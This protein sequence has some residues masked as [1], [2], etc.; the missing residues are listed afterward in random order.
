MAGKFYTIKDRQSGEVL[1]QGGQS[2]CMNFLGCSSSCLRSLAM[3]DVQSRKYQKYEIT[4][5]ISDLV[6]PGGRHE[7]DVICCDCGVLMKNVDATRKR[8]AECARKHALEHKR[9]KMR[10]KRSSTPLVTKK[11]T[12]KTNYCEG[13]IHYRGVYVTDLCC[14]YYFDTDKRRPCPFGEGCTVKATK[15][16][17]R[18][19]RGGT[20]C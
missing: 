12:K 8:C 16:N 1:C 11:V 15:K 14:N 9:E 2:V 18:P 10:E 5:E 4:F 19:F 17:K 20:S 6:K 3:K 7:K 13:C